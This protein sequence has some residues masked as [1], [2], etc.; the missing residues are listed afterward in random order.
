MLRTNTLLSLILLSAPG[1]AQVGPWPSWRGPD[2]SGF[3]PGANPPT[4]W[5]STEN[6]LWFADLPGDGKSTPIIQGDHIYLVNSVAARP[7]TAEELAGRKP[8]GRGRGT[9]PPTDILAFL[10]FALDAKDGEVVWESN[11]TERLQ[12]GGIHNT[13]GYSSFS[14]VTDGEKLYLS[15]GSNGI[16]CLDLE[17]GDVEWTTE[18]GPQRTRREF[19]EAGSPALAGD[20]LI[21]VADQEDESFIYALDKKTGKEKWKQAR[22]ENTTWTTPLV[23]ANEDQLQVIVN[24]TN[25]VRSYNA[26]DGKVLWTCGGQ[27]T[28]PIPSPVSDGNTVVVTSGFRGAAMMS[29]PLDQKGDLEE[30][31]GGVLWTHSAGTPYVPSPV[32][33]DGRVYMLSGNKGMISCVDYATGE[34]LVDRMR[35]DLGNVYA[36]ILAA[37]DYI[38]VVGRDGTT[39][40]LEHGEELEVVSVN[41]L[42]KP[43]DASPVA[44]GDVLYLRS[45]SRLY[46]IK[47]KK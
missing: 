25:A 34:V 30:T 8:P 24:G 19:G 3:A 40:V 37:G 2:H 32:L 33:V 38:Y 5:S 10:V 36:S 14:P 29:F 18:I 11:V 6:I 27:T 42:G 44:I 12:T 31:E 47:E 22:D 26:K 7:A 9:Q 39:V 15:L 4:T 35:L 17:S 45:D 46:A 28:N 16:Y 43:V 20:L 23:L 41:E 1:L 21:V 13:N